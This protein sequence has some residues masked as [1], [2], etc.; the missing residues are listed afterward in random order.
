VVGT[1]L[2]VAGGTIAPGTG[3]ELML[4]QPPFQWIGELSYSLYLWH[5]PVLVIAAGQAGHDLTVS[6]NLL[7]CLASLALSALGS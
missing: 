1:V 7:L 5:W 6:Q 4:K 3:A 2:A